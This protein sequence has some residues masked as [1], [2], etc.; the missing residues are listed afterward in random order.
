MGEGTVDRQEIERSVTC[1]IVGQTVALRGCLVGDER[2]C[3]EREGDAVG[4]HCAER[5]LGETCIAACPSSGA[6][7]GVDGCQAV[8][9]CGQLIVLQPHPR[10]RS[11]GACADLSDTDG[12]SSGMRFLCQFV[13]TT[14]CQQDD[15]RQVVKLHD[16]G[17]NGIIN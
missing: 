14:Y 15:D 17:V 5:F 4:G 6:S 8:D 11:V 7:T 2:L 3:A 10:G 16:S 12:S 9:G 13:R 1:H